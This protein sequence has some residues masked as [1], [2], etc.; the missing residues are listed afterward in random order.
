MILI[1]HCKSLPSTEKCA[2]LLKVEQEVDS[3]TDQNCL[4]VVYITPEGIT[5]YW[6]IYEDYGYVQIGD[7]KYEYKDYVKLRMA[8]HNIEVTETLEKL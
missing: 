4:K 7:I 2:R 3:F 8:I 5:D 6:W 1:H